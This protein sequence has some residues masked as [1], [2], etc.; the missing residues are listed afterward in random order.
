MKI[1]SNAFPTNMPD[2]EKV[3]QGGPANFAWLFKNYIVSN[4]KH[5]WVG[6]LF[7]NVKTG[8]KN[9]KKA[10]SFKQCDF[11]RL[12]IERALLKTIV[13]TKKKI[14][15]EVVLKK[16][17]RQII[18]LIKAQK[19][20]VIF[21]NGF[22]IYPWILLKAAELSGV[23]VVIQHAGIWTKE[24]NVH[25]KLYS[26]EGRK[27]MER[28][29]KDAT[30][31]ASHE[32][33]LNEWSKRYYN[34]NI[35]KL[36]N[37][38]TSII[39][40]PFDF[41]SFKKLNSC[42]EA[43]LFNFSKKKIHIGLIARWDEIKNHKA[44]LAMAKEAKKQNLPWVFHSVVDIPDTAN[45][46]KEKNEYAKYIDIIPS[47]HRL[48]ISQFCNAVDMLILPSIFDVS[49]TVV[50]EAIASNTPVV[51]SPNIGFAH[52]F[53]IYGGEKWVVDFNNTALALKH[54]KKLFG[55]EMPKLLKKRI[56]K[57]HKFDNVFDNYLRVF[58]T[59]PAN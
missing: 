55:K 43:P 32:V 25:K 27:V 4:T 45:Y 3:S 23:P 19:P 41:V 14:D 28:M 7:E 50:L 6:L 36:D 42:N 57:N 54:I 13:S 5:S 40:L 21:L 16:P 58:S 17:I 53:K 33:F 49:P 18:K 20:D 56:K 52:E 10:Y 11:Y 30:K 31:I 22:G 15:P 35:S 1:L 51:I 34:E 2:S 44:V 39:P 12:R 59:A 38:K 37:K 47:L 24:L 29:E 46:R 48:G 26:T 8:P 9:C